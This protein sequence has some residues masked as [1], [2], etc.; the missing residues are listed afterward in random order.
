M[1]L[2]ARR[3]TVGFKRDFDTALSAIEK[4][5]VQGSLAWPLSDGLGFDPTPAW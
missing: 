2:S 1:M 5:A 3:W 4:I